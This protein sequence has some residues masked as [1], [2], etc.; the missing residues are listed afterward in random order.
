[1]KFKYAGINMPQLSFGKAFPGKAGTDYKILTK[2]DMKPFRDAGFNTVH[3]ATQ[4]ERIQPDPTVF[5]LTTNTNYP[6]YPYEVTQSAIAAGELGLECIIGIRSFAEHLVDGKLRILGSADA[7]GDKFIWMLRRFDEYIYSF[8]GVRHHIDIMN[9]P[10]PPIDTYNWASIAELASLVLKKDDRMVLACGNGYS[11]ASG[12]SS[13]WYGS[14]NAVVM[15]AAIGG[16]AVVNVHCYI[17]QDGSGEYKTAAV[18]G[19]GAT[20]LAA[21]TGW[22]RNVGAKLFLGEFGVPNDA[23]AIKETEDMLGY[24]YDNRDVWQGWC[25]WAGGPWWGSYKLAI[26]PK[27]TDPRVA[28]LKR[29]M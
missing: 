7:P 25:W 10:R 28:M 11:G 2:E 23:A 4:W 24:M 27:S 6:N 5:R 12:W 29:W 17:D 3:L 14:S 9:E 13:N 1:M 26:D 8:T 16:G 18:K 20:V 22:A 21:V 19:S 15:K